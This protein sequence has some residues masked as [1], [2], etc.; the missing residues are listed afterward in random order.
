MQQ[1][2][3]GIS[4][5]ILLKQGIGTEAS[6]NIYSPGFSRRYKWAFGTDPSASSNQNSNSVTFKTPDILIPDVNNFIED[7]DNVKK[8]V[9]IVSYSV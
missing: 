8:V 6:S 1:K 4:L 5:Q 7:C 2:N 9:V 3:H